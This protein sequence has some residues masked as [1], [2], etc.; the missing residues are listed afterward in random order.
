EL[1][2]PTCFSESLH[3]FK[4][5]SEDGE[6][7]QG[8]T[9]VE[10]VNQ[11]EGFVPEYVA[12]AVKAYARQHGL[13]D[14]SIKFISTINTGEYSTGADVEVWDFEGV[15][16]HERYLYADERLLMQSGE[17]GVSYTCE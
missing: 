5:V 1:E 12:L 4:E 6:F 9:S 14:G 3:T 2:I 7:L 10:S 11:G 13:I 15:L 17:A 8:V 16:P